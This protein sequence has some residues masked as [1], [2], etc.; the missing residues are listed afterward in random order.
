MANRIIVIDTS[1]LNRTANNLRLVAA[2]LSVITKETTEVAAF[3]RVSALRQVTPLGTR[4]NTPGYPGHLRSSYYVGLTGNMATVNT[5]FADKWNIV[6]SRFEFDTIYPISKRALSWPGMTG[7]YPENKWS[8]KVNSGY[9]APPVAYSWRVGGNHGSATVHE[10]MD[11]L[12]KADFERGGDMADTSLM[13][14]VAN[15]VANAISDKA[16]SYTYSKGTL[17]NERAKAAASKLARAGEIPSG[18]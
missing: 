6:N 10:S 11:L 2:E 8:R 15:I 9:F 7:P 14:T 5:Y 1:D 18:M 4:T 12:N 3:E 17:A 16:K 13:Q